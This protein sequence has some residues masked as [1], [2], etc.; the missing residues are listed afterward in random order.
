MSAFEGGI[1]AD[2]LAV[3]THAN[4]EPAS[5]IDCKAALAAARDVLEPIT[6]SQSDY[7]ID[8][9]GPLAQACSV[10]ADQGQ[11][12]PAM[13]GQC[14]LGAASLLTQGLFNVET[15]AGIKPLSLY[16]LTL[17]DSGDGKSTAEDVALMRVT[18]W[19]RAKGT[20]YR[21][22]LAAADVARSTKKDP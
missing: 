21:R 15:M 14:L 9:L 8:A 3:L 10:I 6:T 2:D 20:A 5:E 19:Q 13:V 1:A 17:G 7:P 22:A 16:L 18:E 11:L 4:V 12:N